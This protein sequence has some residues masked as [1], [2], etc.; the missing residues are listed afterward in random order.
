MATMELNQYVRSLEGGILGI[1]ETAIEIESGS[2]DTY[3]ELLWLADNSPNP[4]TVKDALRLREEFR[5]MFDWA[6][7]E[8]DGR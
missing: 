6:E 8:A 5:E 1:A 4:E 7:P 2:G 3:D